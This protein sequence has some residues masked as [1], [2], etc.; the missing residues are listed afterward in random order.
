MPQFCL[1]YTYTAVYTR[2]GL[3]KIHKR[4][5]FL[6]KNLMPCHLRVGGRGSG[7]RGQSEAGRW[8]EW[9]VRTRNALK[10]FQ[11]FSFP[12]LHA[13]MLPQH[14]HGLDAGCRMQDACG[15]HFSFRSCPRVKLFL[16]R[17]PPPQNQLL[18]C[19]ENFHLAGECKCISLAL[20]TT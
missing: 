19:R 13:R 1:G 5:K 9:S 6:L 20:L 7:V 3:A 14:Q 11:I 2:E 18:I 16:A 12:S 4:C 8:M 17:S 10:I 15:K